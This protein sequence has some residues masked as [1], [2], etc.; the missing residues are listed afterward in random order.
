ME[1]ISCFTYNCPA[2][3]TFLGLSKFG[4]FILI[5]KQWVWLSCSLHIGYQNGNC[6]IWSTLLMS[7]FQSTRLLSIFSVST[8]IKYFAPLQYHGGV[9]SLLWFVCLSVCKMPIEQL[10]QFLMQSSLMVHFITDSDSDYWCLLKRSK[11]TVMQY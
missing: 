5:S 3:L 6:S 4:F 10:H 7:L 8:N 11:I 2:N 1:V 9:I